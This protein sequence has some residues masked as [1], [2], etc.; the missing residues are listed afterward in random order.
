MNNHTL[1]KLQYN[2]LKESIKSYCTSSLGKKLIDRLSPVGNKGIVK[3]RL[4]ETTEAKALLAYSGSI[5]L[6]GIVHIGGLLEKIEKDMILDAEELSHVA[7]FLRGC[8]KIKTYMKDKEFYAP[9]LQSYSLGIQELPH[10][11]EEIERAIRNNKVDD[12]A[13]SELKK[14]RRHLLLTEAEVEEKLDKFL[15]NPHHKSYIQEFFISRRQGRL[16]I[17]IKA[18]YKNKIEGTVVESSNKTVFIEPQVVSKSAA[19]LLT[20]RV[21]EEIEIYKVLSYLTGLIYDNLMALKSNVEIMGEY[22]MIFAK[23]KYSQAIDGIS[24]KLNDYGKI[25]LVEGKHPLLQGRVIPLDLEIGTGFRSLIITGPNA[26]G[27]TLVLKTIGLMTLA[28]QSGFHIAAKEGT[29]FSVFDKVFVDIGDDQSITNS[30]STFSSHVK[31]LASIIKETDKQTLL[32]FDEIGS[33]TEP[34]EGA[35]LAIAILEELYHRGA[36]T[37]ATTHYNEIKNFSQGHPDFE[38]AAMKFNPETLEPLYKLII[39]KSGESNALWISRKMGV[40]DKILKKAK[41]YMETKDYGKELV[42]LGRIRTRQAEIAIEGRVTPE[43]K[44][45]QKGDRVYLTEYKDYG[46]IYIGI[47]EHNNCQVFFKGEII[48]V[49]QRQLRLSLKAKDLYPPDY[50]LDSLFIS[51]RERKLEKDIARGSK[52]VL[53]KIRKY[54][55]VGDDSILP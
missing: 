39:G 36:I 53:K 23:G 19:S 20:L 42:A 21:E 55:K 22:D 25:H 37:L 24:P 47:D 12:S 1:E 46:L 27:K 9:T 4:Q 10:V 14:I 48:E 33:G 31:N 8:K 2:E 18:A 17:P 3:K 44:N 15:K 54:G 50:D 13:S 30:L 52:K 6:Q 7:T 29:E 26:G 28:I 34:S 49:H 41:M 32:L 35:A 5:P 16:T 45:F 11:G 38:N 43:D 51:F 40:E